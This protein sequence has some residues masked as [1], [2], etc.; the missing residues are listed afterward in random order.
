M[1]PYWLKLHLW[2]GLALGLWLSLIGLTGALLGF[3]YELEEWA[4][5]AH[6]T[7]AAQPGGEAAYRPWGEI[8]AAAK[9]VLPAGAQTG[10]AFYPRTDTSAYWLMADVPVAGG[11]DNWHA[12]VDPYTARALGAWRVKAHDEWYAREFFSF[13]FDLHYQLLL[14]WEI[15]G[16]A[17]GIIALATLLSLAVG[18]YLWWPRRGKWRQALTFKRGASGKRFVYDLHNLSG[19]YLL[20]VL[21]A[22]L[23]SGVYFNLPDPFFG[24][25]RVFSPATQNRYQLKSAPPAPGAQAIG[26]A[27]AMQIVRARYPEGRFDWLY[28]PDAPDST[29]TVCAK[30]VRSVSAWADRRCVNVDRYSGAILHVT[31]AGANTGGNTFV[32]WQWPLHSGAAFGLPGRILVLLSG[33][34]LPVLFVTGVLRWRH[35]AASAAV[36]RARRG[37][38]AAER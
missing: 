6:F 23:L 32:A 2:L 37:R 35:K 14:P 3:Y 11:T 27:R 30:E 5:P 33:L 15:G 22:V 4:H 19:V 38:T 1:R 29:Y 7:V 13:V 20:P 16:V 8:D 31:A 10:F 25:V 18:V 26:L 21:V 34:A 9:S 28:N 17:V 24:A 12:F 36:A